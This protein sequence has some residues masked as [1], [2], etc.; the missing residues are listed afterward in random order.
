MA[1]GYFV[2]GFSDESFNLFLESILDVYS[3]PVL[4]RSRVD[5]ENGCVLLENAVLYLEVYAD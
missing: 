3:T 1:H 4:D 5:S 2:C